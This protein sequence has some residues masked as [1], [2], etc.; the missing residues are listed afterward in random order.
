MQIT[1]T[2]ISQIIDD[3][4]NILRFVEVDIGPLD[5][6]PIT[7]SQFDVL[8]PIDVNLIRTVTGSIFSDDGVYTYNIPCTTDAGTHLSIVT[9]YSSGGNNYV[10]F[11]VR[12]NGIFDNTN[13]DSTVINRGVLKIWY[14]AS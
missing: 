1:G 13:F 10:N 7:P 9:T 14:A 2:P 8:I 6:T 4:G 5:L 12:K 11:Y 3:D